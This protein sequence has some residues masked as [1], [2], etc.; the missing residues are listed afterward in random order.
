[1]GVG[2]LDSGPIDSGPIDSGP[3]DSGPIDSG[4]PTAGGRV[5]HP[6]HGKIARDE[7]LHGVPAIP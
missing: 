6:I 5:A 2:L 7:G 4:Q 1:M 3:I